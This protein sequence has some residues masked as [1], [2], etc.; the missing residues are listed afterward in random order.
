MYIQSCAINFFS[1]TIFIV[2]LVDW[3]LKDEPLSTGAIVGGLFIIV[4][5]IMLSLSTYREMDE[6]RQKKYGTHLL[7]SFSLLP[8]LFLFALFPVN[9]C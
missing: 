3:R 1:L 5:F 7:P 9:L 4:A 8:F 2:A 6:E